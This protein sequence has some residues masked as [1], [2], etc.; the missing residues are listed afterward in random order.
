MSC[1]LAA[2]VR[3]GIFGV[4]AALAY[5]GGV[6]A[7]QMMI[8]DYVQMC[9]CADVQRRGMQAESMIESGSSFRMRAV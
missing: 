1:S 9:R 7:E 4:G 6:E 2:R 8:D 3:L 5:V